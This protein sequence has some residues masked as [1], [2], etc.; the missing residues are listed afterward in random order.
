MVIFSVEH[1]FICNFAL[2]KTPP[3][4]KLKGNF[5]QIVY[6]YVC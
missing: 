1:V 4:K 6:V 3:F 2:H 5:T